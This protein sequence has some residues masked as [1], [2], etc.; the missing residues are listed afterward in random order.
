MYKQSSDSFVKHL[1]FF[2]LD[3]LC[4]QIALIFSYMILN[5]HLKIDSSQF[6]LHTGLVIS[7]IHIFLGLFSKNYKN[8]LRRDRYMEFIAVIKHIFLELIGI[9][10]YI[11]FTKDSIFFTR[12]I[13]VWFCAFSVVLIFIERCLWK[14]IVLH[15]GLKSERQRR[16]V[17]V[18]TYDDA[19]ALLNE[20]SEKVLDIH[21]IGIICFEKNSYI[22]DIKGIPIIAGYNAAMEYL[23]KN[24][25]DEVL[26]SVP[27]YM[28][29]PSRLIKNCQA[30]GLTI[31]LD[32]LKK[33]KR[34]EA[35]TIEKIGG[36][37]VL[38]SYVKGVTTRQLLAKRIM[39][40]VGA[41]IGLIA[42][43]I[44]SIFCMPAIFFADPGP[45]FFSQ[46]RIGKNGRRFRIYKFRSM[47]QNAEERKKGLMEKNQMQG[48]MF[49]M[50]ADPRI[51]GSGP[52]GTRHGLGYFIRS[53]SLDEFPQFWN[54]LKGDMSLVGTR[55]PTVDEWEKYELHHRARMA[56]KPGLTGMWQVSGRSNITNFEEVVRLDT[57]YIR[58]WSIGLDIEILFK[59]VFVVILRKGS[60]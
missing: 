1:D 34:F 51:I 13:A 49:K 39:D 8:I 10:I 18:C 36:I 46:E 56:V 47:Y 9:L 2:M 48:Y 33:E 44:V 55:P 40:I 21:V 52:D 5:R 31:H 22:K 28:E 24:V 57:E 25:V 4:L 23:E 42:T 32:I 27:D 15:Y 20:I 26:F 6:I 50:D 60:H 43:G 19:P 14:Y 59:T 54:V 12:R 16:L 30:M 58:N 35:K 38:S 17:L 3:L 11:F 41:T 7:F 37:T 53:T 45:V 29:F